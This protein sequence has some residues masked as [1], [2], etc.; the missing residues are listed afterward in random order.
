[1]RSISQTHF[2]L[3]FFL[4]MLSISC[5]LADNA[6]K[7]LSL[8][9]LIRKVFFFRMMSAE[10]VIGALSSIASEIVLIKLNTNV[11]WMIIYKAYV[12]IPICCF[13]CLP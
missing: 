10:V 2:L 9:F 13:D 8:I 12:F 1:M 11:P 6:N 3:V 7:I 5:E 4:F